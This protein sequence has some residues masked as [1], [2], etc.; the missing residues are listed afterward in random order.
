MTTPTIPTPGDLGFSYEL[1]IDIDLDAAL[2]TPTGTPDWT[3][4]AFITN[5]KPG[6]DKN[7]QDSAT[8]YNRGAA[9]QA[10][11]GESWAL[12]FDHQIQRQ[13]GGAFI[14]TLQAL[15]DASKFGRRNKKAQVHVRWYDTEGADWAFEGV[16]YVAMERG[17]TGNN[18]IGSW[19]FT[20]T[21]DGVATEIGNP[22][23]Q[24]FINSVTPPT[25]AAGTLVTI[26]GN[27]FT[28]ATVVKFGGVTVVS[29][30]VIDAAHIVAL[31]PAGSAGSAP[32]IVTAPA[33]TSDAFPYTR[34]A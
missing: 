23:A 3:Q 21:G 5:V 13:S 7:F 17:A 12:A 6:N 30:T 24:P 18:D 26:V 11:T 28:G 20:L 25:A 10:I 9:A 19:S 33:G 14:E 4:L 1:Q 27:G 29:K 8:Y 16:G 2:P 32:V 15:V 22:Y 34:G 31:M